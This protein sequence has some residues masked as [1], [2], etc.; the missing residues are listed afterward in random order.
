M[1]LK[2]KKSLYDRHTNSVL[3]NTVGGPNGTGP[4]P[5]EGGYFSNDGQSQSPFLTKDG[6][7]YLKALL[8]KNVKSTN[9]VTSTGTPL[10]YLPSP[11]QSDFQ[12]LDGVTGGQGYFHGVA[13]PGRFQ[14]K[15]LG[16]QDLH[17]EL[18]TKS[19]TYNHGPSTAVVG[20]SPGPSGNSDFQDIDGLT[21]SGY[22]NPD[23]GAGF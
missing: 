19:Y 1:S 4:N 22:K 17:R 23:T 21:P 20:P 8:T 15:Q 16:G 9:S 6:G 5:S 12:D 2:D 13:N 11:N 14:G 7:D 18:L 3:G 10:T